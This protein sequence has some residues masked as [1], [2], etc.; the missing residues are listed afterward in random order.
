MRRTTRRSCCARRCCIEL[1]R[2]RLE[3]GLWGRS[4]GPF[5]HRDER[6][7]STV[8]GLQRRVS[9]LRARCQQLHGVYESKLL[10]PFAERHADVLHEGTFNR[11]PAAEAELANL[12]QRS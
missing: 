6:A 11:S 1:A 7:G 3:V 10:P 4:E 2:A 5:E 8:S 9:N 12:R